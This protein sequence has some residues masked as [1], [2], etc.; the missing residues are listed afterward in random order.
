MLTSPVFVS[1]SQ[2]DANSFALKLANDLRLAGIPVWIDQLDIRPGTNWDKEIEKALKSAH[3]VL[4]VLSKEAVNSDNVANEI[5]YAVETK[6]III[7]IKIHDCD[8]PLRIRR[9]QYIDFSSNYDAGI[10][11]LIQNLKVTATVTGENTELTGKPEQQKMHVENQDFEYRK[12][13][14]SGL[15]KTPQPSEIKRISGNVLYMGAL[16]LLI[17][18]LSLFFGFNLDGLVHLILLLAVVLFIVQLIRSSKS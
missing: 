6:K 8:I 10:S 12:Q 9:L 5:D 11:R 1:Y 15:K 18:W 7:P 3:Y 17:V 16:F 4:F 13:S 14:G 2:R